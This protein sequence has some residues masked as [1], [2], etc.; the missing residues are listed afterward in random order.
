MPSERLFRVDPN[1]NMARFYRLTYSRRYSGNGRSSKNGAEL[2]GEGPF[3]ASLTPV[4]KR[5]KL[6]AVD[7]AAPKSR[8]GICDNG[9]HPPHDYSLA[10]CG[11]G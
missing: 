6:P 1:R 9:Q 2:D 3:A 11:V 5:P 7:N 4:F 8:R 10:I